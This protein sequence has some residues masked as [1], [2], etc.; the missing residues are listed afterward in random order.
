MYSVQTGEPAYPHRFGV[1][2]WTYMARHPEEAALFDEAMADFTRQAAIAVT[3]AYDFSPFGTIVDVGGG[4]GAL[5]AGILTAN[6]ELRGVLF[7]RPGVVERAQAEMI[8]RGL[9][10]RCTVV[11]GDFFSEVP[12]GGDA[13]VLKHVIH[14]WNDERAAA[15]LRTCRRA[16]GPGSRLLVVEGV[17]PARIDQ[18]DPSRGAASNDVNMLVATGGRQRSEAE[19]RALYAATGFRLTR[20]VPT[21]ARIS[22]IEGEPV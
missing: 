5:L 20:I 7:D 6:P 3:A 1:D 16:A 21:A 2:A 14:D 8:G 22:V 4:A 12:A 15:I 10:D 18:S 11:G 9:A 19:F 13:Y 17:Y